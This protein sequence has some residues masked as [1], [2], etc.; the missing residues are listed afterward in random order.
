MTTDYIDAPDDPVALT[1]LL[2]NGWDLR[3]Y[4]SPDPTLPY[5]WP[6]EAYTET[7]QLPFVIVTDDVV[8]GITRHNHLS[9]V[10]G[11]SQ[12]GL[13]AFA[14]SPQKP[15]YA[16]VDHIAP[17]KAIG[18]EKQGLSFF[19]LRQYTVAQFRLASTHEPVWRMQTPEALT[20]LDNA[21]KQGRT[22]RLAIQFDN[23]V[24]V[25]SPVDIPYRYIDQDRFKVTTD[26]CFLPGVLARPAAT[27]QK[28]RDILPS[29]F[30]VENV[31]QQVNIQ[32]A[33][34]SSFVE[35]HNDGSYYDLSK[36][37]D[38]RSA[39]ARNAIILAER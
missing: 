16:C 22:F 33:T 17:K 39:T 38:A 3:A 34:V 21:I 20:P 11:R 4:L 19:P 35:F 30:D 12:T 31:M 10:P 23:D 13:N 25:I 6:E 1:D 28:I 24:W 26:C 29:F 14:Y 18:G 9:F 27:E 7:L 5:W 32:T 36:I 37:K 2:L 15:Y 8:W